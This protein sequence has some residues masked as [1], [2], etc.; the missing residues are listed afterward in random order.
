MKIFLSA[1]SCVLLHSSYGRLLNRGSGDSVDLHNEEFCTDV[2]QYSDKYYKDETETCCTTSYVPNCVRKQKKFCV[3]VNETKCKAF[4][5]PKCTTSIELKDGGSRAELTPATADLKNCVAKEVVVNHVKKVPHCEDK[6]SLNCET[7]WK[8]VN[9]EKVW[10]GEEECEEVT[11]QD[12]KL[13][14][15]EVPFNAVE[16]DCS[17]PGEKEQ[18]MTCSNKTEAVQVPVTKCEF[19]EGFDCEPVVR[20]ECINVDY[21]DCSDPIK[22]ENCQEVPVRRP[23]QDFIHKKKCLLPSDIQRLTGG[24]NF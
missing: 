12:C 9:G 6:T 21:N 23:T 22:K 16:S 11:W 7:G 5:H 4:A 18:Y 19:E 15:K 17:G 3:E 1:L 13:V 8:V 2:S 20:E 24:A 14:E 10:S